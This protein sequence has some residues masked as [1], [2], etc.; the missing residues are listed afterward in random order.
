MLVTVRG[1]FNPFQAQIFTK[2]H[3][4][5]LYFRDAA[6]GYQEMAGQVSLH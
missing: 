3:S 6:I 4:S 1:I 5:V 2:N